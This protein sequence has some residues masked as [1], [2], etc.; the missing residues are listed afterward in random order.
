MNRTQLPVEPQEPQKIPALGCLARLGWMVALPAALILSAYALAEGRTVAGVSPP[1]TL[2]AAVVLAVAVRWA[3]VVLL[4]GRT[5]DGE[6]ATLAS[7]RRYALVV[8][9]AGA[10]L[11]L[12]GT[13]VGQLDLL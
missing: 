1:V 13:I 7:W 12:V 9:V 6:P 2:V 5:A 8:T 11:W 4:G 3:D 10:V